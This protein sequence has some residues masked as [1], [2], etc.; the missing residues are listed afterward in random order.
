MNRGSH[1]NTAYKQ[2]LVLNSGLR[3]V[4]ICLGVL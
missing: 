3:Q 1:E 2:S 4:Y